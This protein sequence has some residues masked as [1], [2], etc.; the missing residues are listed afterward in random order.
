VCATS[1]TDRSTNATSQT[2]GLPVG[3]GL[4]YAISAC[5]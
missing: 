4:C 5:V 1:F 2:C 3:S